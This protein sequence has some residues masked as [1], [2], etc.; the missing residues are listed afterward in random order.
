M[1]KDEKGSFKL[2]F[3]LLFFKIF[4]EY[5]TLFLW[6]LW[7]LAFYVLAQINSCKTSKKLTAI[8]HNALFLFVPITLFFGFAFIMELFALGQGDF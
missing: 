4:C 2:P 8:T 7:S 6:S 3:S 5:V 1:T